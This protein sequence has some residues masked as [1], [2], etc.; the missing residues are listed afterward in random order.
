MLKLWYA[1][2]EGQK[3]AYFCD[4]LNE[5]DFTFSEPKLDEIKQS[6]YLNTLGHA[7]TRVRD[8]TVSGMI[9]DNPTIVK[10]LI[11][12]PELM[13]I[14]LKHL[15]GFNSNLNDVTSAWEQGGKITKPN[16]FYIGE[17]ND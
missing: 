8:T 7:F 11:N 1:Q 14:Q 9:W 16:P 12:S 5:G 13:V 17:H 4:Q 10:Y 6:L 3:V 15:S 2:G